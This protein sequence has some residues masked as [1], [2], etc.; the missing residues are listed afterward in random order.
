[1]GDS[2]QESVHGILQFRGSNFENW[3]FRVWMYLDSLDLLDAIKNVPPAEPGLAAALSTKDKKAKTTIIS[4][5]AD[6][7]LECVRDKDTANEMWSALQNTFAKKSVTSQTLVRKQLALLKMKPGE[8]LR[9]H[10]LSFDELIRK[11]KTSGATLKENDVVAQLFV[12]LP[13]AFD[14]VVAA[15]ENMKEEDLTI[16]IVKQRLLA[17]DAKRQDRSE[18]DVSRISAFTGEKKSNKFLGVCFRC[19]KRGHKQ[20]DCRVR[21]GAGKANT[22]STSKSICFMSAVSSDKKTSRRKGLKFKIDSGATDHMCKFDWCFDNLISISHP[23]SICVA[24]DSEKLQA[25]QKGT[26]KGYCNHVFVTMKDVLFVKGLRDNL[27]SVPKLTESG[28]NIEFSENVALFRKNNEVIMKAYKN[29]N[30]YELQIEVEQEAKANLSASDISKLWHSR[31]G[32]PGDTCLQELVR[33]KM[34]DGLENVSPIGICDVCIEGKQCRYPFKGNRPKSSRVLERIHTDV[35]GPFDPQTWDGYKYFVTFIDDYSHFTYMYLLKRKSDVYESFVEFE[36]MATALHNVPIS[37]VTVDQGT[38]YRSNKAKEYFKKKGIQIQ[39]TVAY[40]PQQNGVAER[41]N[42]TLVE[43]IRSML[44]DSNAPKELWGEAALTGTYLINRSP[45]RSIYDKKTPAEIW[46]KRKPDF[47]K[48]RVFGCKAFVWVPNQKRKKLDPK[49]KRMIMA[50]YACNGYRLW[51]QEAMK[52]VIARDVRFDEMS[53][54]FKDNHPGNEKPNLFIRCERNEQEGECSE[55]VVS[56]PVVS[57]ESTPDA[58]VVHLL[59]DGESEYDSTEE[60][61]AYQPRRSER[62]KDKLIGYITGNASSAISKSTLEPKT[63][64]EI[65]SHSDKSKWLDAVNEELDSMKENN[66]WDLVLRPDKKKLLKSKWVFRVKED[67]NGN[68]V[69]YKARLVAKGFLQ[70]A[71]I[72][73]EETYSPVAKLSTIRI[74]LAASVKKRLHLHQLDVKA[75]FLYGDLKET[76]YMEIPDGLKAPQNHVCKLRKSLYG[77]KQ[78]P[79]CW[80]HKFNDFIVQQ[81]FK[82]SLHDSCL[83][84]MFQDNS[85]LYLLLYVDDVLIAGNNLQIIEKLKDDLSNVFK[86][87]DCG[88][89]TYYLGTK[90][91]YELSNGIMKL[92]QHTHIEKIL[93][94]FSMSDCNPMRTPME[95]G[96]CLPQEI[97]ELTQKPYRE[98]LGSLMYLMLSVRPDI[99]YQIGY[100]GRFQN[101]PGDIHWT[102]LKRI[103]RYIKGSKDLELVYQDNLNDDELIGFADADWASDGTDRKSVSG[104]VFKVFGCPVSWGSK[105]QNVVATSSSEAEYIALSNAVSEG[106]WIRGILIDLQILSESKPIVIYED[107]RGCIG[108]AKNSDSKRSKHI[109]VKYHFIRDY[110]SKGIIKVEE[111]PTDLQVADM[112]TKALPTCKFTKFRDELQLKRSD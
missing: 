107:N 13:E 83:Y 14:P 79:R 103:V 109:D 64:S 35:C 95:K 56:E 11:L 93:E 85:I 22:A 89:L 59:S 99:C 48:L 2:K 57:A 29:D 68:T 44:L 70:T 17:E 18:I 34:V 30:L 104:F 74:V 66:V 28:I 49:S 43:K 7:Y 97:K 12:T 19:K 53:Y 82:R 47:S 98:M 87:S 37:M 60:V 20:K 1:M 15:L 55:N 76:I 31:M 80:N 110:I 38:E 25:F 50:G 102:A 75:A 54:P 3:S 78:S 69:R 90:I 36:S 16:E 100:M 39:N 94:K 67:A 88:P 73:Y 23:V 6:D 27:L 46:Y 111:I 108:I 21:L 8:D 63:Y 72:D 41:F 58:Q 32:H 106:I 77:L 61:P 105:K 51:D 81:G 4:L 96:L 42:R 10:L 92:S 86:M 33:Y 62:L 71:G 45:C 65:E 101:S 112:F 84:T 40:T 26:I 24:K 91:E 52:I 9:K 5:I